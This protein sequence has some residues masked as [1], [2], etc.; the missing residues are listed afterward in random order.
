MQFAFRVKGVVTSKLILSTSIFLNCKYIDLDRAGIDGNTALICAAGNEHEDCVRLLLESGANF[1]HKSIDGRA[2]L[3]FI[4]TEHKSIFWDFFWR[5]NLVDEICSMADDFT[6]YLTK[7]QIVEKMFTTD[8]FSRMTMENAVPFIGDI[9]A[10][11]VT[12]VEGNNPDELK[13]MT[14]DKD[15]FGNTLL[16]YAAAKNRIDVVDLLLAENVDLFSCNEAGDSAIDVAAKMGHA[17]VCFRLL[18]ECQQKAPYVQAVVLAAANGHADL[19]ALLLAHYPWLLTAAP[20]LNL[21]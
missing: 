4:P 12:R 8:L 17:E 20:E 16:I 19:L 15:K 2:A 5:E 6:A 14:H 7:Q 3:D 13:E 10:Q 1:H 21:L 9:G 18:K 11:F